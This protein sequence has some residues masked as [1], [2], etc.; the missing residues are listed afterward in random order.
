MLILIDLIIMGNS[1][2]IIG[3]QYGKKEI[4]KYLLEN[5]VDINQ[6]ERALD[7][8]KKKKG[9]KEIEELLTNWK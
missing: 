8:S 2:L 7:C 4:V 3:I 6:K 1:P 9:F 5:K